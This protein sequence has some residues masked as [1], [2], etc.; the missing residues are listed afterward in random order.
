MATRI[1][2]TGSEGFVGRQLRAL[3][4]KRGC[5]VVGVDLPG[6]GA[7]IEIDLSDPEFRADDLAVHVGPLAGIIHLAARITRG[8]SV[9]ADARRNLRAIA[10]AP[11]RLVEAWNQR[12]G[13]THLVFCSTIKVYGH[14]SRQP[15]QPTASPLHPDAYCYGSAKAL[16]ERLL[17]ISGM[18]SPASFAIVRPSFVYGP[19]Q[20][21]KTAIPMF[22][23]ACLRGE[24]PIVFGDGRQL[25]DDVL[26]SDFAY[27]MA[28]ACLRRAQGTFNAA[29]GQARTLV[30]VADLCC[31]AVE[32]I[33]GPKGLSPVIDESRPAARWIDQ[34]FDMK[35]TEQELDFV[36]AHL[37]EG[38]KQEARWIRDGAD[39][40]S[41]AAYCIHS[42]DEDAS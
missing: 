1:I 39:P 35:R 2:V 22:L 41:A 12:H 5:D 14:Q 20:P 19:G 21:M 17:E 28:E 29:S 7:N 18:R 30:Q 25:R 34:S 24:N 16:G 8:S 33:G 15:I 9:D 11:V 27:C 26:V 10:E 31:R 4:V 40:M 42:S 3:L 36:P 37:L 13:P 32:A 23:N 38:L 6:R